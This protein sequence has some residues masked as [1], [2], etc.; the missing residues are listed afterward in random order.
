MVYTELSTVERPIVE[1]LQKI[2]WEYAR[3]EHL[4]R[5]AEEPFDLARLSEALKRL[6]PA[7][8]NADEDVEKVINQL[9]RPLN[10]I[11]GNREFFEWLKG[12]RSLVLKPGEKARTIKLI[13][14]ES[15]ERNACVVTNQFKFAGYENVRFDIVLMVN[16]IPL[17]AIEAKAPTREAI[18]YRE[19]VKQILRYRSK[20]PRSSSISP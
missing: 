20:L 2:G 1:W 4:K 17:V 11:T 5:D 13:D 16:G 6:N 3:P 7:I 15:P 10:D 12:E 9:R 18:D 14:F 19:A 8:V